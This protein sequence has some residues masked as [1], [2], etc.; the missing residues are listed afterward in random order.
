MRMPRAS[1]AAKSASTGPWV[2]GREDHRRR[3]SVPDEGVEEQRCRGLRV[4]RL[5]V[6]GL[7]GIGVRRQPVEQLGSVA[8][9]D[10]DLRAVHV[11]VDEAGQDEAAG[12]VVPLEFRTRRLGL[13]RD[14]ALAFDEQPVAGP[15]AQRRRVDVAPAR[16]A[17]EVE[18]VAAQG[19]AARGGHARR[20]SMPCPARLRATSRTCSRSQRADADAC[21]TSCQSW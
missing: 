9:H 1:A 15:P 17:G 3:R 13:H 12:V 21:V 18:Q 20:F 2:D 7:G 4:R 5:V 8:R 14:D 6:A 11:R 10:V 19:E 16:R